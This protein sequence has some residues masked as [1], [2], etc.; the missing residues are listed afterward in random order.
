V[1]G[2]EE[3]QKNSL[4]TIGTSCDTVGDTANEE[5]SHP[6][7]RPKEEPRRRSPLTKQPLAHH[8]LLRLVLF[9]APF[10][11]LAF[12]DSLLLLY[13]CAGLDLPRSHALMRR[14]ISLGLPRAIYFSAYRL[15]AATPR[16]H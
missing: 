14:H 10:V 15:L 2:K 12:R 11:D 4:S 6:P 3:D 7:S 1:Q 5:D 13:R 9:L 8:F 16:G